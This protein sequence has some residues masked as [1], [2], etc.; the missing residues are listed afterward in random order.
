MTI[1][2]IF[3]ILILFLILLSQGPCLFIS[4]FPQSC[5]AGRPHREDTHYIWLYEG[6]PRC[7]VYEVGK[8]RRI[9]EVGDVRGLSERFNNRSDECT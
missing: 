4:K 6:V 7:G 9:G 8:Y 3:M 1:I 2:L 5:F